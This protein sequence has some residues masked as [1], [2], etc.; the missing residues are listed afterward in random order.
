MSELKVN[1]AASA[2]STFKCNFCDKTFKQ[3]CSVN[4]HIK[5]VHTNLRDFKCCICDIAFSRKSNLKMHRK[6]VH[7]KIKDFKCAICYKE[8]GRRSNASLHI[9]M[10]HKNIEFV[11]ENIIAANIDASRHKKNVH[12]KIKDDSS[13]SKQQDSNSNAS[14]NNADS[15][16]A[17]K[18]TLLLTTTTTTTTTLQLL[19]KGKE[20]SNNVNARKTN[21]LAAKMATSHSSSNA[22]SDGLEVLY[23]NI[24]AKKKITKT[25]TKTTTKMATGASSIVAATHN[26]AKMAT[27]HS[28]SNAPSDGLEVLYENIAAKKTSTT[29]MATAASSIVA[30]T[31]NDTSHC[32]NI[33][34]ANAS[35][36]L[37]ILYENISNVASKK[38]KREYVP[39]IT[40][41][42]SS[43]SDVA[44][45]SNAA[46]AS[47]NAAAAILD[48]DERTTCQR[49]SA[50]LIS[51]AISLEFCS[52]TAT[53]EMFP[54]I[55]PYACEAC[56]NIEKTNLAFFNHVLT[57]RNNSDL[58]LDV[59]A[60]MKEM[61]DNSS[62]DNQIITID[63][64]SI[65]APDI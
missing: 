47:S 2:D 58:D 17:S 27:S 10:T 62:N 26:A 4:P 53:R 33:A 38:I 44:A 12:E 56:G 7:E 59:I 50:D 42:N 9:K 28:S 30:A 8:F 48:S 24:A 54:A 11:K 18:T 34:S 40:T 55:G 49:I 23:E 41:A 16:I 5:S 37:E 39:P 25:T 61:L 46:A 29:K 20:V 19:N 35:A 60:I 14:S 57:H 3:R 32:D 52:P 31:H 22:P 63:E 1:S 21:T 36:E 43:D 45:S 51:A 13:S 15:S 64:S 6:N 65:A